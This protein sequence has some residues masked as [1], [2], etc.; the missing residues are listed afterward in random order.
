MHQRN[1]D[2]D[3]SDKFL[4][5]VHE[6]IKATGDVFVVLRYLRGAGS[7]DHAFCYTPKM[8]YQLVEK[9]PDGADIVVFRKPQLVLRGFCDGDFVEAACKLV[10]DGEESLLLLMPPK[11]SEGLCQSSRSQMSHDE[12]RI[13]AMDYLNQ[14]IAF[15]PVPRWFDNDHDDMISAS[16]SGLDGPR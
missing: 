2:R 3:V 16:K 12:L 13:E 9:S 1:P 6:W 7:R 5:T 14:L 11:D 4:S 8:F 15:G 10:S